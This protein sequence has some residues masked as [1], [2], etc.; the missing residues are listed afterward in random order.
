LQ[1]AVVEGDFDAVKRLIESGADVNAS[2][3]KRDTPLL[4]AIA[5]KKPDIVKLLLD[6]GARF[7][8]SPD[9][10]D[11]GPLQRAAKSGNVQITSMLLEVGADVN[12]QS[13]KSE[14]T[15]TALYEASRLGGIDILEM[16]LGKGADC[17]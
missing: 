2:P 12:T 3:S 5:A 6:N 16:L 4:A 11:G 7:D 15:G 10:F 8:L 1:T 14:F 9:P 17:N 13:E